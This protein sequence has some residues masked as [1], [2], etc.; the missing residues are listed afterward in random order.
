NTGSTATLALEVVPV[1]DASVLVNDSNT[2]EEGEVATGNV[3]TNDSDVDNTLTVVS[4]EVNGETHA[5]GTT[6][7]LEGGE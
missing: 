6:I 5:A 7:D 4:F 3:L 1:D 2:I